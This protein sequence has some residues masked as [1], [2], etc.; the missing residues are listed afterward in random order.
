MHIHTTEHELKTNIHVAE[1]EVQRFE[2][3]MVSSYFK[4]QKVVSYCLR[5][6]DLCRKKTNL[7]SSITVEELNRA[8]NVIIKFVQAEYFSEEIHALTKN[9][10]IS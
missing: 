8:N 4:L 3:P 9:K 1:I 2:L 7:R 6:I 5:F 10:C